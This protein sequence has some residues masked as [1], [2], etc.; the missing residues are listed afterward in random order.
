MENRFYRK[1]GGNLL[2][3]LIKKPDL[4]NTNLLLL[5]IIIPIILFLL[6]NNKGIIQ[7]IRLEIESK[8]LQE[9][10]QQEE[11]NQKKLQEKIHLLK[12]DKSEI[13]KVAREKY[14]MKRPGETIYKKKN[15]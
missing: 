2:S 10:I 4:S 12:T 3:K 11:Q 15:K 1:E 8:R 13:E 14:N 6:L 5:L 7:R 9:M